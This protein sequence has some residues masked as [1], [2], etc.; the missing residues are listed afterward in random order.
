MFIKEKDIS[1]HG[2]NEDDNGFFYDLLTD[3]R[4]FCTSIDILDYPINKTYI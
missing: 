2:I 4:T 3:S 1:F